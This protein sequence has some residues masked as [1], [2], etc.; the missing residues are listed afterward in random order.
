[1]FP[2]QVLAKA[3]ALTNNKHWHNKQWSID[4]DGYS[5]KNPLPKRRF[6]MEDILL[7]NQVLKE[8]LQNLRRDQN[9]LVIENSFIR[10]E[11]EN[12]AKKLKGKQQ[13]EKRYL[14]FTEIFVLIA[15]CG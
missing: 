7:E 15:G 6:N 3:F 11:N 10:E 9:K 12:N 5:K 1:M 8:K 14:F 2:I 13:F 4:T